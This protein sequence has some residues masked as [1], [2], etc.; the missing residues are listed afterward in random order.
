MSEKE[1]G[2]PHLRAVLVLLGVAWWECQASRRYRP[3][4]GLQLQ[5]VLQEAGIVRGGPAAMG[6]RR[7]GGG[8]K[9]QIDEVEY[10]KELGSV[11]GAA[12]AGKVSVQ[13]QIGSSK[14]TPALYTS[15]L[16][17]LVYIFNLWEL[18]SRRQH[19][20]EWWPSE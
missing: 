5:V 19:F 11:R 10:R 7:G 3:D 8:G 14:G 6:A 16:C 18:N 1:L 13:M 12:A 17:W 2:C 20:Y 15:D 9:Q 4:V